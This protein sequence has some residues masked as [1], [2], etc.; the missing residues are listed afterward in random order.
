MNQD[1]AIK[2]STET[3]DAALASKSHWWGFPDLPDGVDFPARNAAQADDDDEGEDLLTFICQIRL[4]DIAAYDPENLL[5]HRGMLY[6]FAALDYFLGDLD[7]E[8]GH[9]GFWDEDLYKVIYVPDAEELHTHRVV[10][11]DGTEACLKGESMRFVNVADNDSGH[12]LLGIPFFEEVRE[13]APGY[14]SL[15]Q[16]DEDERWGLRFYDCGMLNFLI[17]KKDLKE[18]RFDK[19]RLY[20]HSL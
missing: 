9:I 13:E 15:L 16:V 8:S 3:T 10:W 1:M 11:D 19:V 17:S 20:F 7:A 5:P 18:R 14:V 6:F 12:K 4:E 2:I